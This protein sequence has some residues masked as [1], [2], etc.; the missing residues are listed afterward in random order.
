MNILFISEYFP[1]Y[2]V[3]GA[4][5]STSLI[6]K[7]VSNYSNC[8][9]L[10]ERYQ[11]E[12]WIFNNSP[13]FPILKRIHMEQRS[14]VNIF[15]YGINIIL[16]PLI[17]IL[18]I[19]NFIKKYN[20]DIIHFIP[21][22]YYYSPLVIAAILTKKPFVIDVRNY[23]LVCPASFT[24]KFCKDN[25]Y[26][27]HNHNCLKSNYAVNNKIFKIINPVFAL[28]EYMV[29]YFH[30][31]FLRLTLRSSVNYKIIPNSRFVRDVLI[32]NGYPK[33]KMQVI[34]NIINILPENKKR[35]V[36]ERKIVY[37]GILEKSKGIWDVVFAFDLLKDKNL[38]LVIAGNGR[39]MDSL[40]KYI[41]EKK[42]SN[43]VFTGKLSNEMIHD[44]YRESKIIVAPS[45]FPEPFGRFILESM[46]TETP[47]ITTNVG[48]TPEGVKNRETG[49]ILEPNNPIK[50][51]R[52]IK[53]LLNNDKLYQRIINN[54]K[55][56]I[57]KYSPETI[58]Q[59]RLKLYKSLLGE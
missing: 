44:L 39:E 52:A 4:E 57:N 19:V 34:Y 20:I 55:K 33:N 6:I 5:I 29:F 17:N 13:V 38:S 50:L 59:Q 9:I 36:R 32:N 15:R 1:P 47:L 43:I 51:A 48:G 42:I 12:P 22:A 58:G 54:L 53:E 56:E 24:S 8:Y 16:A 7:Y 2:D 37:A 49:I 45:D 28:Y 21:T 3:G 18:V 41:K 31:K 10:T 26:I 27:K 35:Y 40:K 11:K 23:S 14:F 25:N 46:A 30:I